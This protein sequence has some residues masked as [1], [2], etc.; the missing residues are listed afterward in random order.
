MELRT[1]EDRP[2]LAVNGIQTLSYEYLNLI[3][4]LGALADMGVSR[5]RLS[6]HSGDM[7]QLASL[8]RSVLDGRLPPAD[9]SRQIKPLKPPSPFCN[10]FYHGKPG[11]AWIAASA[12]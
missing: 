9:A 8:F 6:P 4:E 3:G 2:F 1:L 11:F 7:V 5:F 10:G 12:P